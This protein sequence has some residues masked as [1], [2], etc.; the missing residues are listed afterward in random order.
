V[1]DTNMTN[2]CRVVKTIVN[3][4][5]V[6]DTPK[7]MP[8]SAYSLHDSPTRFH[9]V[10]LVT[11]KRFQDL[12]DHVHGHDDVHEVARKHGRGARRKCQDQVRLK[13]R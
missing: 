5:L 9:H 4:M 1:I 11:L 10:W 6:H 8:Q 3:S 7:E 12:S 2:G 13:M